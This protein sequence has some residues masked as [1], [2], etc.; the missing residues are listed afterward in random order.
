MDFPSFERK[1][2]G[3]RAGLSSQPRLAYR[4]TEAELLLMSEGWLVGQ[5]CFAQI[6]ENPVQVGR[7]S[8]TVDAAIPIQVEVGK[9]LQ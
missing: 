1:E 4:I 5:A 2:E 9:D 7:V 6:H 8:I 3:T